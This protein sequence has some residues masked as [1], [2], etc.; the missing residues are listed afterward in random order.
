MSPNRLSAALFALSI[1]PLRAAT[2]DAD[3]VVYGCTSG[4][5]TAAIQARKIGK[6]VLMAGI[7]LSELPK[8]GEIPN[9][10]F[11][12][13]SGNVR[14]ATRSWFSPFVAADANLK[15]TLPHD[16]TVDGEFLRIPADHPLAKLNPL[17][18]ISAVPKP[19]KPTGK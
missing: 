10:V 18:G 1:I 8:L 19:P 7:W 3:I 4:G 9:A 17:P 11:R 14:D 12:G 6:S 2:R 13:A 16:P 15:F 5:V